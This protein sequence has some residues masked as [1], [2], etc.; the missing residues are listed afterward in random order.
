MKDSYGQKKIPR[1]VDELTD[2][3]LAR[4]LLR[5]LWA[6]HD[7]ASISGGRHPRNKL[8]EAALHLMPLAPLVRYLDEVPF[9]HFAA[10]A[11]HRHRPSAAAPHTEGPVPPIPDMD[12]AMLATLLLQALEA[13]YRKEEERGRHDHGLAERHILEMALQ[14]LPVYRPAPEE[15]LAKPEP[16]IEE[17]KRR[18]HQAFRAPR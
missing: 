5:R 11:E 8:L 1:T 14:L 7:R 6:I 12:D 4:L 3:A 13:Y 17:A 2:A 9:E 15:L 18:A 10:E 16:L